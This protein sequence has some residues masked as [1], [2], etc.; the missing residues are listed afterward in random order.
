MSQ[1]KNIRICWLSP[2]TIGC[3]VREILSFIKDTNNFLRKLKPITEVPENSYLATLDV[4]SFYTSIS[5]SEGIKAAKISHEHFTRKR[6]ATKVITT[7]LALLLNLNNFIFN[8]K[9]LQH[10]KVCAM[11]TICAL[12]K[13]IQGPFWAKMHISINRKKIIDIFQIQLS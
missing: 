8:S 1:F 7:F 4:K 6:I 2:A 9:H 10:I 12:H 5:N 3:K 11:G 13:C